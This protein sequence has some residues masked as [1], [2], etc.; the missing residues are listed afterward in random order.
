METCSCQLKRERVIEYLDRH[1]QVTADMIADTPK[2]PV[3]DVLKIL[4]ELED[5][6]II[7]MVEDK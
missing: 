4:F 2:L 3:A 7:E 5:E 1:D 6:G